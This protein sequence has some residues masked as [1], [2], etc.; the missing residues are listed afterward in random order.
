MK[1]ILIFGGAGLVGSRFIDLHS[2]N[3]E[4]TAPDVS[5]LD[6]LNKD[7]ILKTL[8][9]INP[10]TVVNFAAFTNVEGAEDQKGDKEGVCFQVNV[11]GAKNVAE[12]VQSFGKHLIHISTE[13]IF[14]GIKSVSP[15]TEE[16]KPNPI[17]WYGQTK[18]FGEQFVLESGCLAIVARICMPFRAFYELKKDVA[19]FFLE[20]LKL[21]K[22][23]K[24]IE[25]QRV[26]PTLVDD[27][28]SAIKIL[29][30]SNSSG[31]YHISSIDSVTPLEFAKIIAEV[32]KLNYSLISP[33]SLDAY[34]K[35]KKAKLLKFSWL[36]PAKFEKEFGEG[37]LHTVKEGLVTIKKEIDVKAS[38]Q[39]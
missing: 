9:E 16:D 4:I 21:G 11:K 34:N 2:Q 1:K 12:A 38:D 3:F 28:A 18:Y 35:E 30:E 19:R 31:L 17:N 29:I 15:Y 24:V 14:D 33:I 25:D 32:F 23:I 26:T 20:Q 13:Y 7:Q 27:I 22:P 36:N 10:D 6:I 39:I 5:S 8:E 37:I